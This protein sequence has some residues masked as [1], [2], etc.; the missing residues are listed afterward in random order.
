MQ[1]SG[2]KPDAGSTPECFYIFDYHTIFF[3]GPSR[4]FTAVFVETKKY[5][6]L[7]RNLTRS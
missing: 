1:T 6:F 4:E 3:K 5:I 7:K 2:I